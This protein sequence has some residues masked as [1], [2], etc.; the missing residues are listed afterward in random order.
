MSRR[1]PGR[2][3]GFSLFEIIIIVALAMLLLSVGF[4]R[5]ANMQAVAEQ[6]AKN[7]VLESLR[8]ALALKAA[9]LAMREGAARVRTLERTNPFELLS[10]KLSNYGGEVRQP[11]ELAP[12]TWY[13]SADTQ[14]LLYAERWANGSV[15]V[16]GSAVIH[17]YRVVVRF[18]AGGV[19]G[20]IVHHE[21][22][23]KR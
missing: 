15:P 22:T 16:P 19:D 11:E 13:Y 7:A 3:R 12:A 5:F 10:A 8:V 17:H 18:G 20:V 1:F 14:E 2:I 6:S 9:E 21:R 23:T 4:V